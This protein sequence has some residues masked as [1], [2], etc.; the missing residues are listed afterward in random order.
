LTLRE[1]GVR[2][3]RLPPPH[4]AA[5]ASSTHSRTL[6]QQTSSLPLPATQYQDI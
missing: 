4:H 6:C 2:H 1:S 5:F 3:H